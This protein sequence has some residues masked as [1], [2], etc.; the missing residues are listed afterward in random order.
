M[1][2]RSKRIDRL[3]LLLDR[4]PKA[5]CQGDLAQQRLQPRLAQANIW[6]IARRISTGPWC[7]AVCNELLQGFAEA[8][9]EL[10]DRRFAVNVPA[11]DPVELELPINHHP[12]DVEQ[13]RPWAGR[14]AR[15]P[16]RL[17]G[18]GFEQ[19]A[20]HTLVELA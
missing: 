8:L 20:L 3:K 11:V 19:R 1:L 5:V 13:L 18:K 9:C 7:L 6:E 16:T 15:D 10:P 17:G 2:R 14:A 4:P 12:G